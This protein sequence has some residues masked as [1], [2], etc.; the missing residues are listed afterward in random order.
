MSYTYSEFKA[1]YSKYI[2]NKND[3]KLL[4]EA[5]QLAFLKHQG[6][7]RK[8][9]EPYIIHPVNVGYILASLQSG[10]NTLIAGLLHDVVEDTETTL[11]EIETIFGEEVAFLVDGVTK[12]SKL[13]FVSENREAENQQKMLL[14]MSKDIR[15]VLIKIA[16][17]LHNMRTIDYQ[18]QEK[19]MQIANETLDIYAPLAHRLGL[20]L[21]KAELED[22]SLRVI[23]P[24]EFYK[25]RNLVE[26]KEYLH[27]DNLN[28]MVTTIGNYLKSN[29]INKYDISGR[30]KSIYSIY[31]KMVYQQRSF[32]DIY[33]I[34]ALRV[35]V[36]KI[37]T[38][39]QVLGIIHAHFVPIPKRFKDYIAV[40]KPNLYQ[41]LH[42]TV[43]SSKGSIYEIQIRTEE[44]DKIAEYGVAAHWAYK[45][46]RHYSKEREQFEIAQ[47]LKWY[48][49]LLKMSSDT[50]ESASEFV[51]TVK[52]D[53]L[54]A[55]IYVFTPKGQVI[56]LSKNATPIDFAYRIH[57]DVG[58]KTVGAL[59]NN[60]MV[61]LDYQLKTGDVVNI[62]TNKNSP[63]PNENWLKIVQTNHAKHKIRN[64]LNKQNRDQLLLTGKQL[65]EKEAAAQKADLTLLNDEFAIQHFSKNMVK[66]LDA[67][68]IEVGKSLLSP[69]TV[70]A[71]MLGKELDK[72]TLLQRQLDKAQRILTTTH[73]SGIIVE[74]LSTPQIKIANCCL[75]VPGDSIVG[76]VTRGSGI[77]V[78]HKDCPNL[79][80]FD[81]ERIVDVFW[82]SN[83]ERK[84]PTRIRIIANNRENIL[85]D[86]IT[87]INASNVTIAEINSLTNQKLENITT[88][89]LITKNIDDL[90]NVMLN[91]MKVANIY[92]IERKF[93]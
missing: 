52:E 25:I 46:G 67:L 18:P 32:D 85:A 1:L 57:S 2:H 83:I 4:E 34:L 75:P 30:T 45:E 49:E 36:D 87:M 8:S 54:S 10:P 48:Q 35:I 92:T 6:Q 61:S 66:S 63:G 7:F 41:S 91:L 37:E 50:D 17:R 40:P 3:L 11:K 58:D 26:N 55:N 59:V 20:F 81:K 89:K 80:N 74:G 71:R 47:K 64:F 23:N 39:Y 56:E 13:S 62:K 82:A 72:E 22:R 88:I 79:K 68:Y 31:K 9:K 76:F 14:A 77:A 73:V 24:P 70:V 69:K 90:E 44:M 29:K 53:I 38:C 19:R 21:I 65:V 42:T 86:I 51:E 28:E 15:V 27:K 33:D 12:I 78:H 84:Y 5:Y 60:K 93:V 43:L 16:D